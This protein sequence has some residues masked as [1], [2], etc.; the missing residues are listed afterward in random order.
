MPDTPPPPARVS[1]EPEFALDAAAGVRDEALATLLRE[2]WQWTLQQYPVWASRLGVH[3]FDDQIGERSR[4]AEERRRGKRREFAKR[5]AA[6]RAGSLSAGDELT[7]ELFAESLESELATETCE[8]DLWSVS[9]RSNPVTEWNELAE[10]HTVSTRQDADNLLARLTAAP[11][12]I[13]EEI[14]SLRLGAKRGLFANE[15]SVRRTIEMMEK[16][17]RLPETEWALLAPKNKATGLTAEQRT[18]FGAGLAEAAKG[19]RAG[20]TRYLQVLQQEVLPHARGEGKEGVGALSLGVGCYRALAREHTT[21]DLSPDEIHAIGLSEIDR[22]ETEMSEL[23]SKALGTA[24]LGKIRERLRTDPA[25][26]FDSPEAIVAAAERA[27]GAA[28][29]KQAQYVG[30]APGA[31]CVVKRIPDYEAPFS[32]IAY[33]RPP[34]P[35]GSKPGEYFVNVHEPKSRPRFEAEVLAFHESV[36]GHHLQIGVAQKLPD[37]PAFLKHAGMTAYVEGWGLYT[38]RLAD[39]LGLYSSDLDR[40]GMLSF[41]AW[42]AARLVV[43]T[44]IHAKGWSRSQAE[45]YM[46]AHTALTQSNIVNEVDRYIVWPGQALAYKLGQREIL[47]LRAEAERE[48]G[49]AFDLSAFHDEILRRG[50]ISL[51]VLRRV[52]RTWIGAQKGKP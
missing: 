22:I 47:S 26:Y 46:L 1:S 28:Q 43:D 14:A 35:D 20:I 24:D 42:R 21:L 30:L 3:R 7:A 34:N 18:R 5:L 11:K 37:V 13:D 45:A 31:P 10:M 27:L 2:H 48:L 25:L 19:I 17:L 36:P 32:T 23:G 9:P 29:A 33:Y 50:A 38:E 51:P 12:A 41:D 16:E 15:Q 49:A 6:V 4:E 44:G 52:V 8:L 39:E 40:M